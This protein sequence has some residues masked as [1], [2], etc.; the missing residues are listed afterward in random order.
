MSKPR[1]I[2]QE[3]D[4]PADKAA[5][6]KR[7]AADPRQGARRAIRAWLIALFALVVVMIA[8]GGLTRLTDSGLS[9][10]EWAPVTGA[11]PPM[12]EAAWTAEFEKYKEIPEYRLQNAGMTLEEFKFIYWWEWGHRQLGRVIGL[13]WALG[14]LWFLARRQIPPGWTPRLLGLGALGG[15]QGAV[16]WWMVSSGLEGTMLDVA[17]YRLATHLGLA[18]VILGLIAWYALRLSQPQ[19]ALIQARRR[20]QPGL[21]G[22][23]AVLVGLI[24]VQILLGALVAGIDAGRTYI[25]WPLMDGRFVPSGA[26]S[27]EPAWR[28]FF[29]NAGM[30]QFIHRVWAYA[31]VLLAALAWWSARGA[32]V[33]AVR[34]GIDWVALGLFGQMVLGIATVIYGAPWHI[35]IVHQLGAVAVFVLAL[36]ARFLVLYPPEQKIA[37]G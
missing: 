32:A 35:A 2:F 18:F 31:L 25:T 24:F 7:P 37:R 28:N 29:E 23:T 8:V 11:L 19:M 27:L 12:S 16:G 3:V 5:A 34:R 30:V 21:G 15:L 1:S 14:F 13:V 10:T 9:I 4:A 26:M 17:S 22:W 6:P 36:R 33:G 20:R